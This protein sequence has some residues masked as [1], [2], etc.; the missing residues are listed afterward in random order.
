ML[1]T[2]VVYII[3]NRPRLVRE[4]FATIRAQRPAQLFIIADGPRPGHPTD[5]DRCREVREIVGNIDWPCEVFRNFSDK[6]L[7][8]KQRMNTG[9]DWVFTHVE[10]AII[11]ED[12]C[13]PEPSFYKYCSEL[14]ATY[15]KDNRVGMI[16]GNNF[17]TA[18][19]DADL[20]YSFSRHGLIWG[21]ATWKRAWDENLNDHQFSEIEINLLKANISQNRHFV[22]YWWN[23]ASAAIKGDLDTWDYLWGLTRYRNNFLVIRPKVN[24]VANIGFG[25][26][27]TH[28][29][30]EANKLYVTTEAIK[31]PLKHPNMFVP[32]RISDDALEIH[33]AGEPRKRDILSNLSKIKLYISKLLIRLRLSF[34]ATET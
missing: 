19:Y 3:F 24:L 32:D 22:E 20:S 11:L 1:T 27:A 21:W 8:C 28:T 30:G 29:G 13:L 26:N 5:V 10:R 23:G 7:G 15:E 31:F 33:L 17:N 6:N 34:G 9:L 14:L 16:S 25:A 12:D 18:L 2:P 4:T